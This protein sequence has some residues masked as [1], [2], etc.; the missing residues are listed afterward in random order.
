[1]YLTA[2][3]A[4]QSD[5]RAVGFHSSV[6]SFHWLTTDQFL[7][8]VRQARA[9]DLR[10]SGE[11]AALPAEDAGSDRRSGRGPPQPEEPPDGPAPHALWHHHTM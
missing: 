8:R 4:G 6:L 3:N 5:S 11:G 1:M 10:G 9:A 7:T 2:K